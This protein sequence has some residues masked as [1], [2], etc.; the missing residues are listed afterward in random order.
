MPIVLRLMRTGRLICSIAVSVAVYVLCGTVAASGECA[1]G[2]LNKDSG[3]T[4]DNVRTS[5][6]LKTPGNPS[7][8]Y[9]LV[10]GADGALKMKT[11]GKLPVRMARKVV[12][13]DNVLTLELTVRAD[14]T[15]WYSIGQ[16]IST[17]IPHED[18]LFYMPG[19]WYRKN[20]RSPE[21]APSFHA[22]DSWQVREDRLSTPLTGL[23]NE[24]TGDWLTVMRV[25]EFVSDALAP[26]SFGEVM[27]GGKT[28][29]GFTG[30]RN[31]DSFAEIVFGFPYREAPKT[32]LRKRT[33]A[34]PVT[35]FERIEE[36]EVRTLVWE[37][38]K[39]HS[40]SWSDFVATVWEN[41]FASLRPSPVDT[42]YTPETAKAV[43]SRYFDRAFVDQ[44]PL[45]YFSSPGMKTADCLSN[46]KAEVGFIGRVLLNAFNAIEYGQ[47]T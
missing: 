9:A 24:R 33:L 26:Q 38:R 47:E 35:A 16:T 45:K 36:G 12:E 3:M 21:T 17:G 34:P 30:F 7:E 43:L 10:A 40:A 6:L 22:S 15:A 20:L 4:V 18:C 5:I 42:K 23:F 32:Y 29:I 19:F 11:A 2:V 41:S 8:E 31:S 27:L 44:Y 46:T 37:I 13:K 39:G 1:Y 28:S 14:E 25:D